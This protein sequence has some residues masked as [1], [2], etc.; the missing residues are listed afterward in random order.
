MTWAAGGLEVAVAVAAVV[1]LGVA[2]AVA[3]GGSDDGVH[4]GDG[5]AEAPFTAPVPTS[6]T[7][8]GIGVSWPVGSSADEKGEK[9]SPFAAG[10]E[11]LNDVEAG[12]VLASTMNW[13]CAWPVSVTTIAAALTS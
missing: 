2:L 4:V 13:A 3:A 7:V 5:D 12:Q 10:V 11:K 6:G 1:G 8:A 9:V